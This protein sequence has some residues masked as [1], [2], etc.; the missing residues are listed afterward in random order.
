M[1][2]HGAGKLGEALLN[3]KDTVASTENSSPADREPTGKPHVGADTSAQR[4]AYWPVPLLRA[5]PLAALALVTAFT[6]AHSTAFGLI[7]FGAFAVLTALLVGQYAARTLTRTS[8]RGPVLGQAAISLATGIL[9]LS[10]SGTREIGFLFLVVIIFAA[11]TGVLELFAGL[12]T[13]G[14]FVGSTDLIVAGGLTALL[15]IVFVLI[16][17]G[18]RQSFHDPDGVVRVLDAS[19]V[20]IGVLGAY[21]AI[22]AV[23][24][25]IAGL[26]AKW[27]AQPSESA[28]DSIQAPAAE[29]ENT[30]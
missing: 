29:S 2:P 19:V 13:R 4:A 7:T 1:I 21:A 11:S 30:P 20:V 25:V 27:A 24:L 3:G 9:A 22:L 6:A 16:P 17:P 12:R 14:S 15:A 23:F 28:S 5:V 8:L 26:S 18:Y 10:V